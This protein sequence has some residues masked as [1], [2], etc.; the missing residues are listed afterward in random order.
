[1]I[2][3]S[4]Y[5]VAFSLPIYIFYAEGIERIILILKKAVMDQ[6]SG[7]VLTQMP[8]SP[9]PCPLAYP[10]LTHTDT[11]S[12][13]SCYVTV[14]PSQLPTIA[15]NATM[16]PLA[17]CPIYPNCLSPKIS[18][19]ALAINF[20]S[21]PPTRCPYV[22]SASCFDPVAHNYISC[23]LR[24][25]RRGV[26]TSLPTGKETKHRGVGGGGCPKTSGT[27]VRL[28]GLNW[29]GLNECLDCGHWLELWWARPKGRVQ[30]LSQTLG[31]MN[32]N[33]YRTRQPT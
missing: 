20:L 26:A 22:L 12:T 28:K 31:I 13:G 16:A 2:F 27:W 6:L 10:F 7:Y 24:P 4:T 8:T 23:P 14:Y 19:P 32:L 29:I 15:I 5:G 18:W 9:V 17:W 11:L 33:I 1:M 25:R 21:K 3:W 30:N